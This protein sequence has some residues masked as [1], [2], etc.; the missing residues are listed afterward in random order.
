[1]FMFLCDVSLRLPVMA[2]LEFKLQAQA[3]KNG[4]MLAGIQTFESGILLENSKI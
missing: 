1:M 3:L 2:K 4:I